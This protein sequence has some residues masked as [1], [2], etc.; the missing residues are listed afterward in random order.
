MNTIEISGT[1]RLYCLLGYPAK[2][3]VSPFIHNTAFRLL[4]MD[5][6]YLAFEVPPEKLEDA[7]KGLLALDAGGFNLTMPHKKKILPLLDGL[8]EDASLSGSVNTV[9]NE[10]GL[11]TGHTTD[12][13]GY[14]ASLRANDF[15]PYGKEIVILGSG[16]A[17]E[18]IIT[19]LA[20]EK[21]GSIT[22]L[23]RNNPTMEGTRTFAEKIEKHTGT[24]VT[25]VPMEDMSEMRSRIENSQL[26]INATSVGMAPNESASLV[27]AD[28]LFPELFVSDIIYHPRETKLLSDAKKTGCRILGGLP[29]L[30]HQAAESFRL[31]TGTAMPLD[32]MPESLFEKI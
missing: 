18:S 10:G 4:S 19:R 25:V 5:C 1:T 9:V 21:A 12:G 16:G 28:F 30:L 14:V 23:K 6:R 11:L 2:H 7:V 31:W 13:I 24:P 27:P 20:L 3:S 15:E 17:A 8:S 22:I 29:M 26:L 32:V